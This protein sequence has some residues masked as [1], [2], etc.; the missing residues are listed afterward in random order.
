MSAVVQG[1]LQNRQMNTQRFRE[2]YVMNNE[3]LGNIIAIIKLMTITGHLFT[4]AVDDMV[5]TTW[6]CEKVSR[7]STG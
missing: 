1:A 5:G 4:L 6:L 3:H 2:L 7:N